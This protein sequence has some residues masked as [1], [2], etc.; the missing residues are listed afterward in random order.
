MGRAS[1]IGTTGHLPD[2]RNGWRDGG[3]GGGGGGG[4]NRTKQVEAS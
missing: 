2:G 1:G 3:G 4:R